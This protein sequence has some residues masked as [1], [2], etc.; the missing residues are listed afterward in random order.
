[1]AKGARQRAAIAARQ[2]K[3][4]PLWFG[5]SWK[6]LAPL[7][8]AR[9]FADVWSRV[10]AGWEI[11]DCKVW[12]PLQSAVRATSSVHPGLASHWG[13]RD[14]EGAVCA[15]VLESAVRFALTD[16]PTVDAVLEVRP[17]LQDLERELATHLSA[18]AVLLAKR[19]E[20][21][22][23]HALF[24][25]TPIVS[26]DLS[27]LLEAAAHDFPLWR[28]SVFEELTSFIEAS[29]ERSEPGPRLEDLLA[30]SVRRHVYG[31]SGVTIGL[32][33]HR[34]PKVVAHVVQDAELSSFFPS[35]TEALGPHVGSGP[36]ST[37]AR[38]KRFLAQ[39]DRMGVRTNRDGPPVG[40][41]TWMTAAAVA[42]LLSVV[43]CG[44]A[45]A[46]KGGLFG[47][48]AVRKARAEYLKS[49]E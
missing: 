42:N 34:K 35:V 25:E 13:T 18:A 44:E 5:Y 33:G 45:A 49:A 23:E 20:L 22:E 14:N 4:L 32:E 31:L 6:W 40:P 8:D 19:R 27:D 12:A 16:G 7:R 11:L 3:V 48:D 38:V 28:W 21:L 30:S 47:V 37:P 43:E 24:Y 2:P 41:L 1:M 10:E 46:D 36:G 9:R 17:R 26:D 29:R 39:L 15:I